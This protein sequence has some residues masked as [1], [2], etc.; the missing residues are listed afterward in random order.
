M[1]N[2]QP[3]LSSSGQSSGVE[4]Y[5]SVEGFVN[6]PANPLYGAFTG[7]VSV[8]GALTGVLYPPAFVPFLKRG[9]KVREPPLW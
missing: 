4:G 3:D 7:P 1:F 9:Y 8:T 2:G 6:I 5:L